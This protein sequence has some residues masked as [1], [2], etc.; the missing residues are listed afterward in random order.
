[1][2][3]AAMSSLSF[4]IVAP[5]LSMRVSRVGVAWARRQCQLRVL[6]LLAFAHPI[7]DFLLPHIFYCRSAL[8]DMSKTDD[9]PHIVIVGAG[10]AA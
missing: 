5:F 10:G 7:V 2:L 8:A 3:M 1:M 4:A 9:A 6:A